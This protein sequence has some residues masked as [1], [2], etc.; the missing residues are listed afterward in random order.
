MMAATD[1]ALTD[2]PRAIAS[3]PPR[4]GNA[5]IRRLDRFAELSEGQ[6]R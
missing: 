6:A 4:D 1:A 5:T 3:L 2:A